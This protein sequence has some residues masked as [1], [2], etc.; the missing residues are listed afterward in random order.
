MP[1]LVEYLFNCVA[2]ECLSKKWDKGA[3]GYH[4]YSLDSPTLCNTAE[5]GCLQAARMELLCNSAPGQGQCAAVGVTVEQNLT[6]GNKITQYAMT[7]NI[8]INGTSPE[9]IF[10]DGY[11]MRSL[12]IDSN[13]RDRKSVV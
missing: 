13:N 4:S 12:M 1:G 3:D 2:H 11:V 5:F 7:T 10:D 9:H 8:V 6:G